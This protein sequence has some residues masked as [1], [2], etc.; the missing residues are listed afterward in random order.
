MLIMTLNNI[1]CLLLFI[2]EL[3]DS[4]KVFTTKT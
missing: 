2:E 3:N 1:L 4:E